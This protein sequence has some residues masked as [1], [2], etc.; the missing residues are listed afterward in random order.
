[1]DT[2]T[3]LGWGGKLGHNSTATV[4]VRG[5]GGVPASGVTAVA[6]NTTVTESTAGS[7]LTVY[8]S[9]ATQPVAS[10]LNF[11][12]GQTVPNLVK[13]RLGADG[14][15][16]VYNAVGQVHVIFD[17]VG[18]YG[19]AGDG[20]LFHS[21]SP[22]RIMDT[23]LGLGWGGKLGHNGTATVPVVSVGGV[24]SGAKAVIVNVTATESTANSFLAVYPAGLASRPTASNLNF[25]PGQTLPNLVIVKVGAEGR[26]NIYNAA[27]QVHLILDVVGYFE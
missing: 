9:D 13:V 10:N 26:V 2:R 18:W 15:V 17:V 24:P 22:A 6:L 23:R 1:M 4:T 14:K 20:S 11:G 19:G 25:G 8:P 7:Y 5:M 12:P 16:K 21:L 27:G 3:G